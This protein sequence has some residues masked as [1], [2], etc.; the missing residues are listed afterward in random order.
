MDLV[1]EG[2][3]NRQVAETNMNHESSRSHVVLVCT[4]AW[5]TVDE[6]GIVTSKCSRLNLVDLAGVLI[7]ETKG[8][9]NSGT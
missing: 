5:K 2:S 6:N 4:I 8:V 9:G 1:S 3:E 7:M